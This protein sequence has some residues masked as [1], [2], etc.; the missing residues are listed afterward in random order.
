MEDVVEEE[1]E[2]DQ[3]LGIFALKDFGKDGSTPTFV[4]VGSEEL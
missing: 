4:N 3:G 1:T 2:D